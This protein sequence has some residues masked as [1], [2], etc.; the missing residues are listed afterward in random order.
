MASARLPGFVRASRPTS[1]SRHTRKNHFPTQNKEGTMRVE[2][3]AYD[4][5]RWNVPRR[6]RGGDHQS[7]RSGLGDAPAAL[8]MMHGAGIT[9]LDSRL[10]A[11]LQK[12]R[13]RLCVRRFVGRARGAD[14]RPAHG[15]Q[16]D[17]ALDDPAVASALCGA[18]VCGA[19]SVAG[20]VIDPRTA[21]HQWTT[22]LRDGKRRTT[23]AFIVRLPGS[24][25][26]PPARQQFTRT[27]MCRKE[28]LWT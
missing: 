12:S 19:T 27:S 16:G 9:E 18:D 7:F 15:R 23:R 2:G 5:H 25:S 3:V 13:Q 28:G 10:H 21:R 17:A 11:T 26:H 4:R 24:I 6:P 1:H 22:R 8:T 20:L 14:D